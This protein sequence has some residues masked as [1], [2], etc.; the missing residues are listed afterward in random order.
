MNLLTATAGALIANFLTVI[1]L[2]ALWRLT[3]NEKDTGAIVMALTVS[4]TVAGIGLIL[5]STL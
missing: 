4:L 5:R 3:K 2:Y 1:F